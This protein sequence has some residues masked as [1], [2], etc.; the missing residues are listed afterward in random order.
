MKYPFKF[1]DAYGK[2]DHDIF[3]GRDEETEALYRLVFQ[4]N[5][6][7]VYGG[8]G[9]GKTSLI[10]CGLANR[11]KATQWKDLYIRRGS[12]I[13]ES[14]LNTITNNIPAKKATVNM[15]EE[16]E[17]DWFES[18]VA[19]EKAAG[20]TRIERLQLQ[21]D[22]PVAHALQ[23]LYLATFTP[24]YLIF[25]Q[26]EELYTLGTPEEQQ[27]LTRTI[28]ELVTLD[29]PVK[30]IIV[31][32]EEYLARLY[33]L[34]QAVPQLRHKKLRI[35][36]MDLPRVEQ[37]IL[38]ATAHNPQSNIKL[39][40]GRETE[41]ARAII[42]KVREGDIYVKLPYLQVF[43]DRLYEKATG[44]PTDRQ[45]EAHFT[46]ALVNEMG[47]IG[48]VLADFIELQS[49]RLQRKLAKK[50]PDLPN[51]IVW[52]ILSPF[53]TVDGT[54][55]PIRQSDLAQI[56]Q[57]IKLPDNPKTDELIR[58]AIAEL[59]NSRILR[60]R[61]EEDTYE[62]A[63]DTLALQ[64]AEKRSEEEKT[65]LKARR[66]VTEGY[67]TFQDTASY[68]NREQLMFILPYQERLV[69]ELETKQWSFLQESERK[70]KKRERKR[71]IIIAAIAI[72]LIGLASFNY[73]TG[74]QA[75]WQADR[76][77]WQ[78]C[79]A[80]NAK[81][82]A[83][84]SKDKAEQAQYT[85]LEKEEDA[86][87]LA[88]EA[89]KQR[90][91]A[92]TQARIALE[93]KDRALQALSRLRIANEQRAE[94]EIADAAVRV[95]VLDYDEA[96][97]RLYA[98]DAFV[99]VYPPLGRA[100]MEIAFFYG[101]TYQFE[102]AGQVL[103]RAGA[104]FGRSAPR[105]PFR[106]QTDT[107]AYLNS[108]RSALQQ[109]DQ[110]HFRQITARYYPDMV[111]V[112]GGS[113]QMGC[114]PLSND[115]CSD[116]EMPRHQ[117]SLKSFQ[118]ART[119]TTVWQYHLY[120]TATGREKA[121]TGEGATQT[122][123]G[124]DADVNLSWYDAVEY[125]NWLSKQK[126]LQPVYTIDKK[127]LDKNNSGALDNKKW[128]VTA[129]SAANGFRLPTEAEWEYVARGG[130]AQQNMVYSGSNELERVGWY[131][132]NSTGGPN[133]VARLEPTGKQAA[134]LKIYDMSGNAWEW[135]WDWSS[136]DYYKNSPQESPRGPQSGSS[137]II[138][139]GSW[140]NDASYARI[141]YRG[142]ASPGYRSNDI[143]FRLVRSIP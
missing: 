23:D 123:A 135:C 74:T 140:N 118:I 45:A 41:I 26:F 81:N 96:L 44:E 82:L 25:D 4:A 115:N 13:N 47:N 36:P 106:N 89:E 16:P 117:V 1:L 120:L 46:L 17:E 105:L 49:S 53:A 131:A 102:Q 130:P 94:K 116:N 121:D 139:G 132:S 90:R 114:A 38:S 124:H 60:Y 79:E 92:A 27:Q 100:F 88:R 76:A 87:G 11:F 77:N 2:E 58:E 56:R 142:N 9:T 137:R 97:A 110:N 18:V 112:P 78:A 119:E 103:E 6:M 54:K 126:G 67:I 22:N 108:L 138:R 95:L 32:R 65:F 50:Y 85:A 72:L 63:H 136:A 66:M 84:A 122:T 15:I 143:G 80:E 31:M 133:P 51:D 141:S 99:E 86:L 12:D 3:Y 43:M 125:A 101:E 10:R 68:L 98:A 34:E 62:V 111:P 93:E 35:E 129:D 127:T 104:L 14:L 52:Q 113:F 71:R 39:E 8:S 33:E 21:T 28:A 59:E 75:L 19:S 61:K 91:N 107:V 109:L 69:K 37:V 42:D 48:D 5:L 20:N 83:E 30:I 40:K 57:G 24:I 134:D 7:L 55:V 64:I 70:V 73:W 128:L 29:L